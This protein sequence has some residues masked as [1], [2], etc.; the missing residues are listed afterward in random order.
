ME[1]R[2]NC[3]VY[4]LCQPGLPKWLLPIADKGST[5]GIRPRIRRDR[6]GGR[7]KKAPINGKVSGVTSQRLSDARAV[8]AYSP[9]LAQAVMHDG[10][11]LQF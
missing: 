1:K 5:M 2:K 7:G 4:I 8:L 10:K 3:T 9:E 11:P 6:K